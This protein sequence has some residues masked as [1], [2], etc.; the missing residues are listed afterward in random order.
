MDDGAERSPWPEITTHPNLAAEL[1]PD[2]NG[3]LTP[4][5]VRASTARVL[6]WRCPRCSHEWRATGIARARG[7]HRCGVCANRIIR[8]GL[9]DL[10][11]T[12][13]HL[14]AEFHPTQNLPFTAPSITAGSNRR[15]WRRCARIHLWRCAPQSRLRGTGCPECSGVRVV[16]GVNDMATTHPHI[17]ADWVEGRSGV[18]TPSSVKATASKQI[19]WACEAGHEVLESGRMR[20]ARGGCGECNRKEPG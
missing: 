13:P 7:R 20:T 8:A 2:R 9:N 19:H 12:H 10:A 3:D 1:H 4:R 15:L 16:P 17:A 11:T 14:A 6:A 5:N 18:S